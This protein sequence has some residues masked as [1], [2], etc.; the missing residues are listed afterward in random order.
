MR[1]KLMTGFFMAAVGISGACVNVSV[2]DDDNGG[3][4]GGNSSSGSTGASGVSSS[5]RASDFTEAEQQSFCEW[6]T[7][8]AEPK[9]GQEFDCGNDVTVTIEPFTVAQCETE[10][11]DNAGCPVAELESCFETLIDDPCLLAAS[12]LPPECAGLEQCA[13]DTGSTNNPMGAN[14]DNSISTTEFCYD[15]DCDGDATGEQCFATE[16]AY[17]AS[18]FTETNCIS[19]AAYEVE[20]L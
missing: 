7:E 5:K 10:L 12:T 16:E 13:D 15:H 18:L 17:C 3:G 20:C 11:Q 2:S 4:S 9:A 1:Y 14:N 6:F 8:L 19:V